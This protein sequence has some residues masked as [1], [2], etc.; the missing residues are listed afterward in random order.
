LEPKMTSP[1]PIVMVFA[2]EKPARFPPTA[3]PGVTA[4]P[5]RVVAAQ[6]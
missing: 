3:A 4:A 6:V 2:G 5:R 1:P